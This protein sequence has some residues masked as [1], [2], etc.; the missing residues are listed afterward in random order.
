[1]GFDKEEMIYKLL[2]AKDIVIEVYDA[3]DITEVGNVMCDIDEAIAVIDNTS[4][5]VPQ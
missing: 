3:T 2:E 1:M 4:Q 5:E